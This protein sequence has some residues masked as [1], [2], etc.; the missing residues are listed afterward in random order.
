VTLLRQG[1]GLVSCALG[2]ALVGSP[3]AAQTP[4]PVVLDV[5]GLSPGQSVRGQ[6]LLPSGRQAL[7]PFLQSLNL[8]DGCASVGCRP[9]GPLLTDTLD[10]VVR[11]PDGR[12]WRGSPRQL[13]IPRA[14]PG[15]P[16]AAHAEARSYEVTLTLPV[17]ATNGSADRTVSFLL[18]W[19]G[20]NATSQPLT[21][22]SGGAFPDT[23]GGSGGGHRGDLPFTG[24]DAV[25]RLSFGL[26]LVA[27]GGLM[28]ASG[29]RTR[30]RRESGKT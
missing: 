24:G 25:G 22:V 27:G 6:L 8:H 29:R 17:T 10:L 4:P 20:R 28:A 5:S 21:S 30:S 15:G 9:G 14:L 3:A 16:L 26:L 23:R 1:V 18:R 2:V 19:G 7:E 13:S 12:T 11:A